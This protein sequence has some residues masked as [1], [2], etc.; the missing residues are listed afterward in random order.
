LS[1][2]SR[3]DDAELLREACEEDEVKES[4]G[5]SVILETLDVLV[6]MSSSKDEFSMFESIPI[7]IRQIAIIW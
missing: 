6:N 3:N 7:K 2:S 1:K 5:V 4:C